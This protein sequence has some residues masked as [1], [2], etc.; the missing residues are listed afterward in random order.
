[1]PTIC[2]FYMSEFSTVVSLNNFRLVTK[3]KN[4]TFQKVY[5]RVAALLHVRKNETFSGCFINYCVLIEFLRYGARIADSWDIFNIHLPL[6]S[7]LWR[8]IIRLGLSS[9]LCGW[10]RI[11]INQLTISAVQRARVSG[12]TFCSAEFAI[13]FTNR[14]FRVTS[15]IILYPF[16]F[17]ICVCIG[18]FREGSVGFI[19]QGNFGTI[20][21]LFQRMREDLDML[22]YSWRLSTPFLW[23]FGLAIKILKYLT[24]FV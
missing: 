1:M 9:V 21:F 4:G 3:V 16:Q 7:K 19:K 15:V 20:E 23:D 18:M 24:V 14:Y 10:S 17:F 22:L 2:L 5:C 12:I 11:R 13:Q 6:N 8:S